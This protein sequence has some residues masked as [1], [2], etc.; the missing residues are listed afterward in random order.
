M[1]ANSLI[2]DLRSQIPWQRRYF[3]MTTTAMMWAVWLLLWRPFILVWVLVELQKSHLAQRLMAALSHG[4]EH[5]VMALVSCA[6]ALLLWGFLP[7]KRVHKKHVM[8]KQLSN[9]HAILN[10]LNRKFTRDVFKKSPPYIMMK[11]V[12]LYA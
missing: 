10:Y 6:I 9:M 3:S 8:E 4:I 2:I 7:S 11:T 12:K 5:G 1:K